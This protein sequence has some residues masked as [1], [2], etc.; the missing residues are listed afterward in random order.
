MINRTVLAA[1]RL[2]RRQAQRA[3]LDGHIRIARND[4]NAVRFDAHAIFDLFDRHFSGFGQQFGEDAFALR[5]EVLHENKG[6]ASI[7]RQVF[8]QLPEG[9][10]ASSGS[11]DANY[12][13][14]LWRDWLN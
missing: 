7:R 10:Q 8:E 6:Y 3:I 12:R 9:L 4:V 2:A 13:E 5:V 1:R 11:A 14:G